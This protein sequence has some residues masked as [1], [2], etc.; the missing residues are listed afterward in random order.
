[1]D[2]IRGAS[3]AGR[4]PA[5]PRSPTASR[6]PKVFIGS[7][8]EGRRVAEYVQLDMGDDV[9]ATL[10]S[11]GVFG[12]SAS[13]MESLEQATR[14]NEFAI[15][16]ITADDPGEK[17]GRPGMTPRDNVVLELGLF[18]GA[19]GRKRTFVVCQKD[20]R[21][22]IPSDLAGITVAFFSARE[23]NNWEA[24]LG[25][26]CTRLK[27]EIRKVLKAASEPPGACAS[28]SRAAI[29]PVAPGSAPEP[30]AL[31]SGGRPVRPL[32][33]RR[34]RRRSL[35]TALA[36]G[37]TRAHHIVNISVTGAL[38]E[39]ESEIQ[40]GQTLDLE[41][42]LE[43]GTTARVTA[44]VV[45]IQYPEWGLVGGIGVRFKEYTGP[46]MEVIERYVEQDPSS[47]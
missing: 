4:D 11:Q 29:A 35:G 13:A 20:P 23:D 33:A 27:T 37:P 9:E 41:L 42:L 45:R 1:M 46:A 25:P 6:K 34:R 32:V 3:A 31:G 40:Q 43:N 17:R 38:L 15:L 39:T 16:V 10:W 28:P 5:G 44:E 22:E 30:A 36:A 21:L 47:S 12:L 2:I 7:S 19:L 26:I 18:I 24:A 14:D 8:K